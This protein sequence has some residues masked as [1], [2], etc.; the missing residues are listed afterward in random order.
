MKTDTMRVLADEE[1]DYI[2]GGLSVT[3]SSV[4][5]TDT[6]VSIDGGGIDVSL[7]GAYAS[8]GSTQILYAHSDFGVNL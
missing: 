4:S 8:V 5:L 3:D 6:S 1:L 2:A 7:G